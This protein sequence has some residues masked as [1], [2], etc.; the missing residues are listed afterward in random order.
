MSGQSK[1]HQTAKR[2]RKWLYVYVQLKYIN[3]LGYFNEVSSINSEK[4]ENEEN[5]IL[6]DCC[7]D[8]NF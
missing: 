1:I 2:R 6:N 5:L 3:F 7:F 8:V 4:Y